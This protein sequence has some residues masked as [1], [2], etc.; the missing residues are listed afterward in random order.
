ME[1]PLISSGPPWQ[2]ELKLTEK[3]SW[4]GSFEKKLEICGRIDWQTSFG[5]TR[6]PQASKQGRER[7]AV[8][9][10][11]DVLSQAATLNP[12]FWEG[13]S[14]MLPY[15]G[16]IYGNVEQPHCHCA[17]PKPPQPPPSNSIAICLQPCSEQQA[18]CSFRVISSVFTN[19]CGDFFGMKRYFNVEKEKKK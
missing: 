1:V 15:W 19:S 18:G 11:Q 9:T 2:W 8:A 14:A 17:P 5:R 16:D 13:Y 6:L 10:R 4:D 7:A 12:S 3:L